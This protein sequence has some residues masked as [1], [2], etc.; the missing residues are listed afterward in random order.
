M[1]SKSRLVASVALIVVLLLS[2]AI[3]PA[4]A[5]AADDLTYVKIAKA[6]GDAALRENRFEDPEDAWSYATNEAGGEECAFV[7]LGKNWNT[8]S[9]HELNEDKSQTIVIDLKGFAIIRDTGGKQ[10][11][12]GGV[13]LVPEH[14]TLRICDSVPKSKGYKGVV[15][16]VITGGANTNGGGAIT[17]EDG[18]RLEMAGGTIY[19]CTTNEHGGAVLVEG[20]NASLAITGG[21]IYACQTVDAVASCHGGAVYS[22][23][24]NVRIEN[25]VIDSCYSEDSGGGLYLED[26]ECRIKGVRM[27][28]NHCQDNGG[29]ICACESLLY[30]DN[31]TISGCEAGQ[32]GGAVYIDSSTIGARINGCV[33]KKNSALGGKGGGVCLE[34]PYLQLINTDVM[35]NSA[36]DYGGG[37]YADKEGK[38]AIKGLMRVYNNSGKD[39]R[40]NLTLEEGSL[41][42]TEFYS[43]GLYEGSKVG[44]STTASDWDMKYIRGKINEIQ[45]SYYFADTGKLTMT[46]KEEVTSPFVATAFAEG[47]GNGVVLGTTL[48]VLFGVAVY[49]IL[50]KRDQRTQREAM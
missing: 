47:G 40:H 14:T 28:G 44:L 2:V 16:G 32:S 20:V 18:G 17:V 12:N 10:K 5:H 11:R 7:Y 39:G 9:Q 35:S 33:I 46:Y 23:E 15:G 34:G 41:T 37:I 6:E 31:V 49:M 30:L 21:K 3:A 26:G 29:A 42:S 27:T 43:C 13:F 50:R 45:F 25:C 22:D 38:L 24:S 48:A 19:K 1:T 8:T 36:S 4:S